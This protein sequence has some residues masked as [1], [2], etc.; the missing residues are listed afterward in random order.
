MLEK[1]SINSLRGKKNL[2]AFSGG[3]DSSALFFLLLQNGIK[4]D[5]AIVDY[6]LRKESKEEVKYAQELASTHALKCYLLTAPK[7]EKNFEA[8]AREIRYNFFE[9]IIKERTY[10]NL[11]T[12]HHL[13]DRFEW[14][15]MQFCKGAGCAEIAGMQ[16]EQQR[17]SYTLVRPLLHLDKK[18]LRSFLRANK[19]KYFEDSSNLDEDIK[20]NSFRHNYTSPLLDKY[21]QGIKK[22]FDYIDEDRES[23]IK[24][25]EIR[26]ID[27]FA[28]FKSSQNSRADIF[29]IDK[30]LKSQLHMP[31]ANERELLK[32][33]KTVIIGRKFVVNKDRGFIFILP[34]LKD[35]FGMPKEFKEECRVLKI[36]PKLRPYLYKNGEAFSKIKGLL[37]DVTHYNEQSPL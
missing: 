19:I 29:A 7:I 25:I 6:S 22:S 33:R 14:M 16:K 21:L 8:K 24:N 2:L 17:D 12:A 35:A 20:R 5:I 32:E 9:K 31:T 26:N 11:L 27:E 37:T 34:Y 36:E 28:Y 18:E 1:L 15:L 23:L 13:G 3:V 10:N 4:F 30:Y